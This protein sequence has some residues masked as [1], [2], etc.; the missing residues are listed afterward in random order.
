[1]VILDLFKTSTLCSN[2]VQRDFDFLNFAQNIGLVHYTGNIIIVFLV[3]RKWQNSEALVRYMYQWWEII[4]TKAQR[5]PHH[6]GFKSSMV[7]DTMRY[8]LQGKGK[9]TRLCGGLDMV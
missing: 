6:K 2:I 5:L 4:S 8:F 3:N 1:M 9:I 7:R